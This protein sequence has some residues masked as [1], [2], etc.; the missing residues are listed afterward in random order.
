MP[1]DKTDVGKWGGRTDVRHYNNNINV[2]Y[3]MYISK[4]AASCK[5]EWDLIPP[6]ARTAAEALPR[7]IPYRRLRAPEYRLIFKTQFVPYKRAC[8][9]L[10]TNEQS[11][12][13]YYTQRTL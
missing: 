9:G 8:R 7:I 1:A 6:V 5:F 10:N 2:I 4:E 3:I 12:L 13:Y 11:I